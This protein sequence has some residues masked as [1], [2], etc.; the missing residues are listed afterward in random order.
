[1]FSV[2][3]STSST[4]ML[5]SIDS[6]MAIATNR[7]GRRPMKKMITP[8]TRIRAV[9]ML[10][11]RSATDWAM[12]FDWSPSARQ[13]TVCGQSSACSAAAAFVAWATAKMFAPVRLVTASVTEGA[14]A[15][16]L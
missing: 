12:Y 8:T 9:M 4:S 15:I 10:F 5:A 11:C 3:P 16:R 6:G 14:P 2:N 1:M 7:L 13:V